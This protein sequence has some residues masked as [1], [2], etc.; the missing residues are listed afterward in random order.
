[1]AYTTSDIVAKLG[2][3]TPQEQDYI[4][5]TVYQAWKDANPNEDFSKNVRNINGQFVNA[6]K[7]NTNYSY[8]ADAPWYQAALGKLT[9][10]ASLAQNSY[11]PGTDTAIKQSYDLTG[12]QPAPTASVAAPASDRVTQAGFSSPDATGVNTGVTPPQFMGDTVTPTSGPAV[13]APTDYTIKSGDTLSALAKKFGTTV[14][15]L[16]KLNNISN[17]NLIIAGKSLKIPGTQVQGY[18]VDNSGIDTSKASGTITADGLKKENNLNIPGATAGTDL[19][20]ALVAG[21][22]TSIAEIIKALTP[23]QTEADTKQQSLLDAMT[24]LVGDEA[25]KAADQLTAE[26]AAG[27]PDLRKS[28]ADING[29]IL[30]KTAEYNALQV[31][32]Q[33]KPIT[34]DSIIGNDRAILNA[35]AADIGLLT[36]KAQALQGQIS[37]AQDTVNRSID[38]KYST[39]EAQLKVYQAQLDALKPTL[40]KEQK[41]QADARQLIIDDA[42]QKLADT[43]AAEKAQTG[44]VL[45]LAVK[46]PDAGINLSDTP[47]VAQSKVKNSKIYAQ[48]TRLSSTTDNLTPEEKSF[49]TDLTDALKSLASGGDWGQTW[50]YMKARYNTPDA[51]LDT[52]LKKE[53]FGPKQPEQSTTGKIWDAIKGIWK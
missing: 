38:L 24:S 42:K 32:N 30:T 27:L 14:A 28:F 18:A 11:T 49:Q 44:F 22:T 2:S 48:A 20:G 53:M 36:A 1:M 17:P 26:Q 13:S 8:V 50:N 5:N 40:D 16:A 15:D 41:A 6:L 3:G 35:K 29:Q 45:D 4:N 37:T 25:K 7:G 43:K 39:I 46:Y 33:N 21:A 23:P 10:A 47:A 9:G 19:A 52:L 51:T 34:M 12:T 31:A